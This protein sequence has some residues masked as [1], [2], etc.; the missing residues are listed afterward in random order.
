MMSLERQSVCS[1]THLIWVDTAKRPAGIT[2]R[3]PRTRPSVLPNWRVF[4]DHLDA[5]VLLTT[6]SG[7][8]AGDRGAVALA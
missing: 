7:V 5:A 2:P 6:G 1:R 8:V 3:G 4:Y